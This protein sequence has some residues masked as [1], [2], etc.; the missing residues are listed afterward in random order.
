MLLDYEFALK[1]DPCGFMHSVTGCLASR[2]HLPSPSS[3]QSGLLERGM[4][5]YR[6]LHH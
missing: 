2:L 3:R 4:G 1:G 5:C 6:A